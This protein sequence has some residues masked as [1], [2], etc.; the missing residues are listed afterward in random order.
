MWLY[1]DTTVFLVLKVSVYL[2]KPLL[3]ARLS[4][5]FLAFKSCPQ[6]H[7]VFFMLVV[8]LYDI[9]IKFDMIW[10]EQKPTHPHPHPPWHTHAKHQHLQQQ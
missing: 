3:R 10:Y 9:E 5:A 4:Q 1:S 8:L 2:M 6:Y 7:V